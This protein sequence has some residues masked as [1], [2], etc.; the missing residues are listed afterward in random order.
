[1]NP[2]DRIGDY[3]IVR[4]IERSGQFYRVRHEITGRIEAMKALGPEESGDEEL[5]DRFLHDAR[6]KAGLNH[7]NIASLVT[8]FRA[9]GRLFM[10]MEYVEGE[11]LD[12]KL[13]RGRL[14]RPVALRY[15]S[16]ALAGLSYAHAHGVVH[17]DINPRTRWS[18]VA[19]S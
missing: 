10:V 18:A 5:C 3:T 17:R 19:T 16:Q 12:R 15:A 13:A 14:A 8:A 1:M 7:P 11:P 2:G 9:E 4:P 6:V